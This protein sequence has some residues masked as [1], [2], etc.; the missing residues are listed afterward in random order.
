MQTYPQVGSM[1]DYTVISSLPSGG[2]SQVEL[3]ERNSDHKRCVRKQFNYQSHDPNEQDKAYELFERESVELQKLSD[4][5][6]KDSEIRK[7]YDVNLIATYIDRRDDSLFITY[8]EGGTLEEY[9]SKNTKLSLE[10]IWDLLIRL[11]DFTSFLH[12]QN[13]VHRDIKPANI[14]VDINQNTGRL[15]EKHTLID[16][17]SVANLS[18]HNGVPTQ[19][20]SQGYA[21]QA[22]KS[23]NPVDFY[24][25]YY[26]VAMTVL[27]CFTGQ[28]P[29][30]F[31]EPSDKV[32]WGHSDLKCIDDDLKNI[33]L[34]LLAC[35]TDL[36]SSESTEFSYKLQQEI[37]YIKK[38]VLVSPGSSNTQT[39]RYFPEN[40]FPNNK[41]IPFALLL[42][43][44]ILGLGILIPFSVSYWFTQ[45]RV[46]EPNVPELQEDE[47]Q[48]IEEDSPQL[49][50]S[51]SPEPE[52][53]N[54][55]GTPPLFRRPKKHQQ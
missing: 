51:I 50:P 2:F 26:S 8:V 45:A 36:S 47:F 16:F 11:L 15:S 18:N 9:L 55:N 32:N 24:F 25:D 27:Q 1:K 39:R 3:V 52:P 33:V 30:Q 49:Q 12:G 38:T 6:F 53:T 43:V 37:S 41:S 44:G 28:S 23:G 34:K 40:T 10:E 46:R 22:Q 14:V 35:P 31:V 54:T 42:M 4:K 17:G 21:C 19:I 13:Y 5:L 48:D 7:Q 20:C 29:P